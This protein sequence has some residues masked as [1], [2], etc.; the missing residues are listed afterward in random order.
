[1]SEVAKGGIGLYF[2][3]PNIINQAPFGEVLGL[4]FFGSLTFAAL[5]SFVSVV[6]VIISA[7]QDKLKIRRSKV[8]FIVGIPMMIVSVLL[9]GTTTG[10]PMLDVLDKFVNSFGIVAVAFI[11]LVVIVSNE[12]IRYAR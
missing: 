5:T 6:E 12:K 2:C 7:V 11:S 9:F 4:L 1:M 8:T 3:F 10:L